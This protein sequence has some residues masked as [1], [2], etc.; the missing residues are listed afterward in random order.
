M[1]LAEEIMASLRPISG[2][3]SGEMLLCVLKISLPG[4][5][6]NN[7]HPKIRQ[8]FPYSAKFLSE[9]SATLK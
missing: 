6:K 7:F 5:W 4:S 9:N 8:L 2:Q 3:K 1:A